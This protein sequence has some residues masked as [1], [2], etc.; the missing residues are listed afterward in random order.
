[1][2]VLVC[3]FLNLGSLLCLAMCAIPRTTV[4]RAVAGRAAAAMHEHGCVIVESIAPPS[5][6]DRIATEIE[7]RVVQRAPSSA[8]VSYR[9]GACRLAGTRPFD[10]A[11]STHARDAS[12]HAQ[13]SQ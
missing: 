10:G 5:L 8:R 6:L 4:V 12:A 11:I 2:H 13:H 3:I 1:M 7:P 9:E